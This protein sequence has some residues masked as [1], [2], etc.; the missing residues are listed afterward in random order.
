M[1]GAPRFLRSSAAFR[2][3]SPG[4]LKNSAAP[5]SFFVILLTPDSNFVFKSLKKREIK[6]L[7]KIISDNTI[8]NKSN[9][10]IHKKFKK[11]SL[12]NFAPVFYYNS[13]TWHSCVSSARPILSFVYKYDF[14]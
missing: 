5:S 10:A 14:L 12:A 9:R 8:V 1:S 4:L 2:P 11:F 3:L 7:I 6:S 13:C